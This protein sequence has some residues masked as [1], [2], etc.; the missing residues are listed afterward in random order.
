MMC[1]ILYAAEDAKFG[2]PELSI[3][4][5]PGAGGTQRLTRI[6]G[7][8]RAMDMV[9]TSSIVSGK[10]LE[11]LGLVARAFPSDRLYTE[12]IDAAHKIA[13]GSIPVVRLAKQAI[14]NCNFLVLPPIHQLLTQSSG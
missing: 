4:T 3:G 8:Q 12:T 10:E 6:V 2:L 9:L 7:K 13:S 5:I 14:L 11:R 1:D